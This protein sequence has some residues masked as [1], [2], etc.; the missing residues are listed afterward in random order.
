MRRVTR[1]GST[2]IGLGGVAGHGGAWRV[3]LHNEMEPFM[4]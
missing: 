3:S 1:P 2:S 4:H